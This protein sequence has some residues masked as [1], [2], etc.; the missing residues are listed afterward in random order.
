MYVM[1]GIRGVEPRPSDR[2]SGV[3]TDKRYTHIFISLIF[4][5]LYIIIY[6]FKK[7][8]YVFL[9]ALKIRAVQAPVD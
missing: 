3:L 2:Q 9:N 7:I 1:A 4:Y 5:Y 6:F 8:K